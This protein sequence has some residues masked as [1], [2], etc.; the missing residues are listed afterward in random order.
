MKYL[1]IQRIKDSYFALPPEK[2]AQIMA[3]SLAF[4]DDFRK[5]G[6]NP[7]GWVFADMKGNAGIWIIDSPE[8][9]M[10]ISL[11][12]PLQPYIDV[13]LIP[14]VDYEDAAKIMKEMMAA[15]QK[16]AS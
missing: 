9:Y 3:G 10:R 16:K 4:A 13:E 11:E 12:Y 5:S 7:I 6:K 2:Q 14:I 8:D 1:G 15:R